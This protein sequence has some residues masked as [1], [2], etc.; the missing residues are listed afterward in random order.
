[1]NVQ[2]IADEI[3]TLP[4]TFSLRANVSILA[5]LRDRGYFEAH[6]QIPEAEIRAALIRS[7]EGVQQWMQ[8]SGDKRAT[9][10]YVT[11]DDEGRYEVGCV[12]EGGDRCSQVE[13]K[14]R[15]DACAAFIKREI[16]D[17]RGHSEDPRC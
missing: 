6:D 17:I 5:L 8:Y 4:R 15:T 13:Y 14:D 16:E 1:V 2:K 11:Q 12:V 7:P 10:W 9:G 3:A